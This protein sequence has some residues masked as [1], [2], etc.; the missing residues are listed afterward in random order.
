[1][2]NLKYGEK[3]LKF[4]LVFLLYENTYLFMLLHIRLG[5]SLV[6]RISNLYYIFG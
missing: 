6:K 3:N 2:I 5:V 4:C 1:M